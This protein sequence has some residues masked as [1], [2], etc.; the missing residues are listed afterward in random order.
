ML[1]IDF[2]TNPDALALKSAIAVLLSQKRTATGDITALQ[3]IKERAM[4]D[5]DEFLRALE[6]GDIKSR[7]DPLF[8]PGPLDEDDEDSGEEGSQNRKMNGVEEDLRKL[9]WD[10]IPAPQT[11]V[12]MPPINWAQYG[13]VGESLDKLHTD[14]MSRPVDG[15]PARVGPDGHVMFQGG[16]GVRRHADLGIAAPY[17]PARDRIEKMKKGGKR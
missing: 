14:Q 6:K 3:R 1:P 7:A 13:I 15:M 17:A 2:T 11:V 5:P 16:E 4:A 9:S 12:R 10:P 8:N